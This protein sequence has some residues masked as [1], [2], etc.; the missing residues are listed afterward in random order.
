MSNNGL[1]EIYIERNKARY[2][3]EGM[4][5]HERVQLFSKWIGKNKKILELG[6]RDGSLTKSFSEGNIVVGADLDSEALE[7]FRKNLNSETH[8]LDLNS[9]WP[10]EDKEFDVIVASEFIEHLYK[11]EEIIKKIYKTLKPGGLFVG[12]VPNAFS[13]INRIRLFMAQPMKT[14]LS[15]PTHVHQFSYRELK[16]IFNKYFGK[17]E[18][19]PL[20]KLQKFDKFFPGM[21]SFL[22]VF[23]CR[24]DD[25][26]IK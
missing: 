7:L 5:G 1:E 26:L 18:I 21:F 15:D 23:C 14:T 13:L 4:Y 16:R 3:G 6:C 19:V 8:C 2:G 20:G 11:P 17:I 24:K 9:E 25:E 10:F 22:I 12:S